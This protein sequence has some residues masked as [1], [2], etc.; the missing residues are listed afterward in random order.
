MAILL[1]I[2]CAALI[3]SVGACTDQ[4]DLLPI[5]HQLQFRAPL[6]QRQSIL[7]SALAQEAARECMPVPPIA[8]VVVEAIANVD[9]MFVAAYTQLHHQL[10]L[11]P[12]Q[13]QPQ[14]Q[15]PLVQR[16]HFLASVLAQEVARECMPVPP[17]ATMAVELIANVDL[18]FVAVYTQLHHQQHRQQMLQH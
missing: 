16:R 9:P 3:R 7:A 12:I 4:L 14:F 1:G 6:V 8:T 13:H 10:D 15:A 11:L 2:A 18:M 5:Q 17:I